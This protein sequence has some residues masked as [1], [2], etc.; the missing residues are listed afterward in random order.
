M[1]RC[2]S[3]QARTFAGFNL[4]RGA[5]LFIL[6]IIVALF[7]EVISPY[8]PWARFEPYQQPGIEHILGTNDMGNDILS[9][10]I[11]SSRT[12]IS[13]GL[14]AAMMAT[15]IGTSVGLLSGYFKGIVDEAL[16]GITDIVLMIPNIPLIIIL[17]AFLRPSPWIIALI[18]GSLWWT[19]TAR[20]VR[21]RT[22]QVREMKFIESTKSLG[23]SGLH[24]ISS[25]VF[26]NIFQV[27]LPKFILAIASA[28]IAEASISFLGLGDPAMK[29]WGTMISFAFSRGGFINGYWWWY[30]PP[31]I[32]IISFVFSVVMMGFALEED[33]DAGMRVE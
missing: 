7:S 32:C 19:S 27:V 2:D 18:M 23:F 31:G 10:L 11:F 21:S 16:M 22:L 25:D 20:V 13:V 26:P 15:A 30:L 29:S 6:F 4:R 24:I 9:E 17:A 5:A 12:S 1:D 28:M 3:F 14:G 33:Q 8:D